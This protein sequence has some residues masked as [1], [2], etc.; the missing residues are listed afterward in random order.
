[1][2]KAP[3]HQQSKLAQKNGMLLKYLH[4]L[5]ALAINRI[6]PLEND[7]FLAKDERNWNERQLLTYGLNSHD[8]EMFV[9]IMKEWS[10]QTAILIEL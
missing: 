5:I 4:A 2:L 3:T 10:F 1:M 8:L 9:V 7:D 6:S